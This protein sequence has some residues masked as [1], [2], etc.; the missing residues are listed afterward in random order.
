M[1]VVI[2]AVDTNGLGTVSRTQN[3]GK[4]LIDFLYLNSKVYMCTP[5]I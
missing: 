3:D 5:S 2:E 1:V 4:V